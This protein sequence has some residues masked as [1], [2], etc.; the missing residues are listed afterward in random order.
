MYTKMQGIRFGRGI[1]SVSTSLILSTIIILHIHIP[2]GAAAYENDPCLTKN[3]TGVCKTWS[4]CPIMKTLRQQKIYTIYDVVRCGFGIYEELICCPIFRTEMRFMEVPA[5]TVPTSTTTTKSTTTTTTLRSTTEGNRERDNREGRT[6]TITFSHN[7][8]IS[9]NIPNTSKSPTETNQVN[10]AM[11]NRLN[12]NTGNAR[13]KADSVE[14]LWERLLQSEKQKSQQQKQMERLVVPI[15]DAS[16]KDRPAVR[17]CR[18]LQA[19]RKPSLSEHIL[20]GIPAE[21]GEFPH[22]AAI[23]YSRN[24]SRG[25]FNIFCGGSLIESRFVL[26]AAH[27]VA[28]TDI[29]PDFVFLGVANFSN[30]EE[31]QQA[32]KVNIKKV[33]IHDDYSLLSAYNDIAVLELE[34]PV[35]FNEFVYPACLNTDPTDPGPDVQHWVSAWG[36]VTVGS[37]VFSNILLKIPLFVKPL[38]ECNAVYVKY[39]LVSRNRRG[40]VSTQLCAE[41]KEKKKDACQGDSGGPLFVDVD[42]IRKC[43]KIVAVVS[44][45][46]SCGNRTPGLYT[47]VASYL[48]FIESIVWPNSGEGS[49]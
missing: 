33:H 20:N 7:I 27:C 19:G 2:G 25:G 30:P 21:L 1:L 45:G 37:N 22:L 44:S 14:M 18:R 4:D 49:K 15:E 47:R 28:R 41:D 46:F 32:V 13:Q 43:Y 34:R 23:G 29:V 9:T 36:S 26:T 24:D 17:A 5:T 31:M 12:S 10:T 35:T 42:E 40:I 48:D 16:S 6:D 3:S 11:P 38:D 39:G 8:R